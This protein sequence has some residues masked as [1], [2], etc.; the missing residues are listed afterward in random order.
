MTESLQILTDLLRNGVKVLPDISQFPAF[1]DVERGVNIEWP[2]LEGA[3]A[4]TFGYGIP[5]LL[6]TYLIL[7][8]KEVAP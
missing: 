1:E 8:R 6:L 3:L 5:I 4:Q 2:K 7:K